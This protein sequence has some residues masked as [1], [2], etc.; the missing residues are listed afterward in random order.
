MAKRTTRNDDP[1]GFPN[2]P[3]DLLSGGSV[4]A[5]TEDAA[6]LAALRVVGLAAHVVRGAAGLESNAAR[7]TFEMLHQHC[8]F[9]IVPTVTNEAA[10]D[11]KS[12]LLRFAKTRLWHRW[13]ELWDLNAA[14]PPRR[15]AMIFRWP[16]VGGFGVMHD[17]NVPRN[18]CLC[19]ARETGLGGPYYVESLAEWVRALTWVPSFDC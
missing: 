19:V 2:P 14:T 12:L 15:R 7:L 10:D 6:C 11:L 13:V 9:P 1:Y 4:I 8:H 17:G 3:R 18:N 5:A 16:A